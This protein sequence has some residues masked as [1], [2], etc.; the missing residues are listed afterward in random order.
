MLK[1]REFDWPTRE[2]GRVVYFASCPN[3]V[4]A[5]D[6]W[7]WWHFSVEIP[8]YLSFIRLSQTVKIKQ[9]N[10]PAILKICYEKIRVLLGNIVFL[11]RWEPCPSEP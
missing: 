1:I 5:L 6:D 8:P 10:Y 7:L 11:K 3:I 2:S 4:C 9:N